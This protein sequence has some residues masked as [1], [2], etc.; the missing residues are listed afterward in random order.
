[1]QYSD[2]NSEEPQSLRDG[3]NL[4]AYLSPDFPKVNIPGLALA[5][6]RLL[7]SFGRGREGGEG[8]H[9]VPPPPPLLRRCHGNPPCKMAA[10]DPPNRT[11]V[12]V[13]SVNYGLGGVGVGELGM[14]P[15]HPLGGSVAVLGGVERG[16]GG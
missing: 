15:P 14:C 4:S 12:A 13:S 11:L 5:S 1:M 10:Y 8:R 6:F 3:A 9:F 7:S 16:E 2:R